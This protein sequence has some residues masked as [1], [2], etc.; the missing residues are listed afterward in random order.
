[1]SN[2][3][4]PLLGD[5]PRGQL[6][7][8]SAPAGTGKTTLV[9]MLTEEFPSVVRS[10]S[11]TTRKPRKAEVDGVDYYFISEAEFEEKS[12]AG[13]FLEY[14]KLYNTSY[15]TSKLWV[16]RALSL[17]KHVVLVI[18]TQGGLKLKK[19]SVGTFIF[20]QPPSLETLRERLLKRNTESEEVIAERLAWAK[21]EMDD[22]VFYDYKI[23]NDDL[24]TAYQILRSILIAE[25][26]RVY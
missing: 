21:K 9:E 1:M 26:H 12:A 23:V 24:N 19:E 6:F 13:E 8:V 25:A 20:I 18:D 10:I 15:G 11:F 16:E 2:K 22:A 17:G 5:S 3:K 7:I 4:I 14:V